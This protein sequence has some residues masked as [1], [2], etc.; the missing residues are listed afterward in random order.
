MT[1]NY[2][3]IIFK[4]QD[5]IWKGKESWLF[6]NHKVMCVCVWTDRWM[7]IVPLSKMYMEPVY[8]LSIYVAHNCEYA[9]FKLVSIIFSSDISV[10]PYYQ[11]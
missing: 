4:I 2:Q 7:W 10:C 8:S 3:V 9:N 1:Y 11:P 6:K 5:L